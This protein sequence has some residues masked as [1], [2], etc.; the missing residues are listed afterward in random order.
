MNQDY[1]QL[2]KILQAQLPKPKVEQ[3]FLPQF[4]C[5]SCGNCER[6][7]HKDEASNIDNGFCVKFFQNVPLEEKNVACWTS[8][9]HTYLEDLTKLGNSEKLKDQ[10]IRNKRAKKLKIELD[11]PTLF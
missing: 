2:A 7:Y 5:A 3:R 1:E 9:P 8:K 4:I 6:N 10:H 11:Q